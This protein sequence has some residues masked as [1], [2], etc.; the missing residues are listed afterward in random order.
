MRIDRYTQK[1]H[2]ALQT[3]QDIAAEFNH[4]EISNEHFLSALIDQTDGVARPL[5]EKMGVPVDQVRDSLRLE[6]EQ[7]PKVQGASVELRLGNDL[8][9]TLDAAENEMARLKD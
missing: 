7:R 9:M 1:M 8:R 2:E 5:L 4:Q 3:A 6:L